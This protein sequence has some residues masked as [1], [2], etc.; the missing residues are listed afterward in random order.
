M[1]REEALELCNRCQEEMKGRFPMNEH[2][3]VTKIVSKNGIETFKNYACLLKIN[4][5]KKNVRKYALGI[6][7]H[8]QG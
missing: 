3:Y 8:S 2:H 6:N 4:H 7:V 5:F 1:T